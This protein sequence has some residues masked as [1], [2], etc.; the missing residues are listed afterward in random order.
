MYLIRLKLHNNQS[1]ICLDI[2][3]WTQVV[4]QLTDQTSIFVI[5]ALSLV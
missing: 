2:S 4:D 5:R 3:V 1:N